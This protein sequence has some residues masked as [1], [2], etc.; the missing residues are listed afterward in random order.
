ML[1]GTRQFLT[2]A[3]CRQKIV[4]T[5]KQPWLMSR[6]C[7]KSKV[8]RKDRKKSLKWYMNACIRNLKKSSLKCFREKITVAGTK[9]SKLI[10]WKAALSRVCWKTSQTGREESSCMSCQKSSSCTRWM[11]MRSRWIS[12]C[13]SLASSVK[14]TSSSLPLQLLLSIKTWWSKPTKIEMV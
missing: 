10:S 9:R 4:W 2:L 6:C 12:T 7:L 13:W 11:T 8:N 14:C 3:Y 1:T 5:M